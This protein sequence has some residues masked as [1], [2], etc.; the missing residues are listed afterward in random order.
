MYEEKKNA[1]GVLMGMSEEKTLLGRP[2]HRW[3]CNI[4]MIRKEI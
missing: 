4:K 2:G 3:Q 1:Y